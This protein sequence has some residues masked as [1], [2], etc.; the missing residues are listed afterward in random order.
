MKKLLWNVTLNGRLP[1]L[2]QFESFDA[3]VGFVS[4]KTGET[5]AQIA[6]DNAAGCPTMIGD[7]EYD[8]E[9]DRS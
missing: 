6:R 2:R 7:D 4:D 1:A 9:K 5:P 3:A 8:I